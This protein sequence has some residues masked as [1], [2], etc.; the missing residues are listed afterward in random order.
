MPFGPSTSPIPVNHRAMALRHLPGHGTPTR[1]VRGGAL[2]EQQRIRPVHCWRSHPVRC[3]EAVRC[4]STGPAMVR[5]QPARTMAP[6]R[7][8]VLTPS[9]SLPG[10]PTAHSPPRPEGPRP[11]RPNVEGGGGSPRVPENAS[12]R[13]RADRHPEGLN[14]KSGDSGVRGLGSR[15]GRG[16]PAGKMV[17]DLTFVRMNM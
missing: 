8:G 11:D 15:I 14:R 3:D 7:F 4:A 1:C 17:Q 5:H 12:Q 13:Y 9:T 10:M 2:L 16:S 6:R